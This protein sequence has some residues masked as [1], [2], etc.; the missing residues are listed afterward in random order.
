M[1]FW[2]RSLAGQLMAALVAALLVAQLVALVLFAGERARAVRSAQR[3]NIVLRTVALVRL[4][5]ETPAALHQ[6]IL[7]TASSRLV[8]FSLDAA[9]SLPADAGDLA[10]ARLARDF[11]TAL[12]IEPG[13]LR[14]AMSQPPAARVPFG[15]GHHDR[16][17][18][19][20]FGRHHGDGDDDDEAAERGLHGEGARAGARAHVRW[21][22][23]SVGLDDGR[24]LNGVTG[25]PPGLPPFGA[26][27]LFSLLLSVAAVCVAGLLLA[28]RIARPI[29]NLAAASERMGRGEAAQPLAERGP[30][31]VRRATRAFNDM[32]SRIDR[33]VSDRTQ[34]LA[35]ISHDLR[36]P[37]TSLRLRAELVE[38]AETRERLVETID[39]MQHMVE[40][41]LDFVRAEGRGEETREIDLTALVQSVVDDLAELGHDAQMAASERVV[42]RGRAMGIKRALRNLIENAV[43]YGAAARVRIE[44]G[45]GLVR[46]VIA[47]RGPGIA[48]KDLERLFEPFVRGDA[49][50]SRETGGIGLGLAV[51]RTILRSHGGDVTLANRQGG[52]LEAVL[53]L[54]A[55]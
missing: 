37:I 15:F 52:G 1:R 40:A 23:F 46:V 16:D 29:T 4:L 41:T 3:E 20:W 17:D 32:R 18:R 49:S 25:P 5:E 42:V 14:V 21:I 38:E 26:S 7:Q 28:R 13:R 31:E 12:G 35:A 55:A 19:P 6:R 34:M 43:H 45:D 9:P 54:P 27:F 22:G 8:R 11:A 51:A 50:R 44:Q 36:T 53:A 2:P 30:D 47:D 39:E 10:T 48:E 33:F 24:W